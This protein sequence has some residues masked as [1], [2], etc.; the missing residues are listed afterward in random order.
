MKIL[1]AHAAP[2]PKEP[3]DWSNDTVN[4]WIERMRDAGFNVDP[5]LLCFNNNFLSPSVYFNE[6]DSLWKRKDP[7]LL[8]M[9]KKLYKKLKDYDVLVCREGVNI[10]PDFAKN[11]PCITVY[12]CFDDPESTEILS[13]PIAPSFDISM[14][15]NI[16]EL[17]TYKSWGIKNVH[18][19]PISLRDN[20]F[21]PYL[22]KEE[23]FNTKRDIDV[24]I[25]C[26]CIRPERQKRLRKFANTFPNGSYHGRGWPDGYLSEDERIPLLLNTKIGLN[27]HNSTGPVNLRTFYL[28]ANGVMQICDNKANLGKIY[29]LGQE[30]VGYDSIE[31]AI[32]LTRYYLE[33]EE[34]RL[35]IAKA[36][37]ERATNDYN[38]IKS[39]QRVINAVNQYIENSKD[40]NM[41]YSSAAWQYK[42]PTYLERVRNFY[43]TT[44]FNSLKMIKVTLSPIKRFVE[45]IIFR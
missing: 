23:L 6:L 11:L 34:E 36:G 2:M 16:A 29:K 10:H 45:K 41:R 21:N 44:M 28:P 4:A 26:E 27:I 15:G 19:W 40:T 35:I 33:N 25:L 5:F 20:D 17:E 38:E 32:D 31:E 24:S 37:W 14:V 8:E 13:K 42:E 1:F 7:Q 43:I 9:Y 18:W 30:V 22:K 12:G 3:M 39:F